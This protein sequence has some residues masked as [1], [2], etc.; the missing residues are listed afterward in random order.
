[1]M[2]QIIDERRE[3]IAT[4]YPRVG[5][6]WW[7]VVGQRGRIDGFADDKAAAEDKARSAMDELA[8]R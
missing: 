3:L 2:A 1:M 6:W 8:D 5:D 7:T 4:W